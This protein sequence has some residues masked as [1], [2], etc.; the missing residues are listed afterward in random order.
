MVQRSAAPSRESGIVAAIGARPDER[1]SMSSRAVPTGG[2]RTKQTQIESV[3]RA[4]L[5]PTMSATSSRVR[6][7]TRPQRLV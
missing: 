4:A 3:Q 1:L 5:P 2:D 6:R 7:R